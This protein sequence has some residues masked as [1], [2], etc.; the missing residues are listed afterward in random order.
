MSGSPQYG[1]QPI[2]GPTG[3]D[4]ST[5]ATGIVIIKPDMSGLSFGFS[6]AGTAPV[7]ALSVQV[8]N[9]YSI[10]ANGSVANAGTWNT[11]P[12]EVS[13]T[14]VTSIPVTGDTGNGFIDASS[15]HAYAIRVVY[16]AT[17]GI[18]TLLGKALGMFV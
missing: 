10:N 5:N 7:G 16:T 17:S 8:S 18:G 3:A 6:W 15:T 11:L 2:F 1:P 13:G 4:M 14:M 12:F 9:D